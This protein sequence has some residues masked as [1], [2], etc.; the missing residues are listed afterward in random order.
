MKI[1]HLA[2][3]IYISTSFSFTA[4]LQ[5][6]S[7]KRKMGSALPVLIT[8]SPVPLS[9]EKHLLEDLDFPHNQSL[10]GRKFFF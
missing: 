8:S 9:A 2:F 5:K 3:C 4:S 6:T 1:Q 7:G 10:V